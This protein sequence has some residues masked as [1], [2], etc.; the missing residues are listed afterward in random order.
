MPYEK[1]KDITAGIAPKTMEY[2]FDRADSKRS[3][4]FGVK[5]AE[6]TVIFTCFLQQDII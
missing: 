2:L 3:V 1:I 5:G 6:T 4:F